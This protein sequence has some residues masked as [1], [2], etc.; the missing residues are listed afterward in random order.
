MLA[1]T[2]C[3]ISRKMKP[4]RLAIDIGRFSVSVCL[5]LLL[6]I[7]TSASASAQPRF[8]VIHTFQGGS[9][10]ANPQAALVIDNSGA[11]YGTTLAG[12]T[13]S[14]GTVFRL[15]Q[16]R[17]GTTWTES[18][19]HTFA[20]HNDGANP[21]ASL[22][23]DKPGNLYGTTEGGGTAGR[24]VAFRLSPGQGN[25][26]PETILHSFGTGTDDAVSPVNALIMDTSGSLYGSGL[27]GH[28]GF[29]AVFKLTRIGG[30]WTET[31]LHSFNEF[32][33]YKPHDLLPGIFKP[34]FGTTQ[35]GGP[36]GSRGVV[37]AVTPITGG[38]WLE[39]TIHAFT[40]GPNDGREPQGGLLRGS[41]GALY[42][43]A[44]GGG[45]F[46]YGI[47]YKL[48]PAG[49]G[50][51]T[52]TILH[53]F[54]FRDGRFPQS[55]LIADRIGALYGTTVAGGSAG[56]GVVFKLTPQA[57]GTY[58]ETVLHNFTGGDDGAAPVGGLVIDN[59]GALYGTTPIGG[60]SNL[61]VVFRLQ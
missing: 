29:G 28:L 47:A 18:V 61:G 21:F 32:E 60:R 13:H 38:G 16:P 24:G 2:G 30:A 40:D 57:N 49:A 44:S 34:L 4:M 3:S 43:T 8:T 6:A 1:P 41:D 58:V 37:F 26:W 20:G 14:D 45:A 52:E 48:T 46:G 56:R 36:T 54:G 33:G 15:T 53:S 55:G 27:G 50:R 9:D 39:S 22:L 12:G 59:S 10:G 19:I 5:A 11:L 35:V 23:L 31:T 42:G 25:P 51:W 7:L 17:V